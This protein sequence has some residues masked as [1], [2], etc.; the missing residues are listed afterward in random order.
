MLVPLE[1]GL[2]EAQRHFMFSVWGFKGLRLRVK[3]GKLEPNVA[4]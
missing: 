3:T 1:F 2:E 4:A